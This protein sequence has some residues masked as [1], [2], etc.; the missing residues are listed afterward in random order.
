MTALQDYTRLKR[1]GRA[2]R[3]TGPDDMA[4]SLVLD[5]LVF[6]AEAEI[7]WLDH[8]EA[9]LRRAAAR[10][11]RGRPRQDDDHR[12]RPRRECR[13]DATRSCTSTTSPASTAA[14]RPRCTPC[15]ASRSARTPASWSPSWARPAPASPRC[16]PWPAASTPRPRASS[17]SRASTSPALGNAGRAR[18]RR[19]SIGYVFQD[20]NLIPALTAAENVALPRELDGVAHAAPPA[21]RPGRPGGGRHRSSSP[22]ASPTRC[23]AASSSGS[24]S[25][26]RWSA[27]AGWSS[28]TSRPAPSTPRPARTSCAAA[29]PLRRGRGRGAGH[30]RGAARRLGGPG[31]LPAR[32]RSSST[33]PGADRPDALLEPEPGRGEPGRFSG[34]A[35]VAADRPARRAARTGAQHPR[36]RDDR[37]AGARRHRGRHRDRHPVDLR[38]RGAGAPDGR[39]GRVGH[40]RRGGLG[41]PGV[42]PRRA[43][44]L[45]RRRPTA[46]G[47]A[48][49]TCTRC[50]ATT[51]GRSRC[52]AR[53]VAFDTDQGRGR[54]GGHRGGP[55]ATRWP[56]GLF[57]LDLGPAARPGRRGRGQRRPGR[58]RARALGEE[59]ELVD[60]TVATVVGLAESSSYRGTR[61]RPGRSAP[62]G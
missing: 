28:P 17:S 54:R 40:R 15:A 33:R 32:R 51:S 19:T 9:R 36:P 8:C 43:R 6:S 20:F 7:R 35:A 55:A 45:E 24:R 12:P 5:S 21:G 46:R 25:P 31:G 53:S 57:E 41:R 49:T 10:A 13:D 61:S 29:R 4:W 44:G 14:A 52:G 48:W 16:S 18:M 23:P 30:P 60:G 42:R 27:S 38:A 59:L 1:A 37:A 50:W 11:A 22:T 39:R 2:A 58:A 34:L 47:P 62:S 56:P 3:P 26:A